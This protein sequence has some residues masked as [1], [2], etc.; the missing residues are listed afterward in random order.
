MKFAP[1]GT[2]ATWACGGS[3]ER[4]C[5]PMTPDAAD[6]YYAYLVRKALEADAR[7]DTDVRRFCARQAIQAHVAI[8]DSARS[9]QASQPIR[10]AA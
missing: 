3:I 4:A 8:R 9:R 1:S 7:G 2:L 10:R 5:G 6:E